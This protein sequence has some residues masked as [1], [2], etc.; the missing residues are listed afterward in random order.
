M[1]PRRDLYLFFFFN[2]Q[3]IKICVYFSWLWS[4]PSALASSA[5]S[6]IEKPC[7]ESKRSAKL[8]IR[9]G[10]SMQGWFD[11]PLLLTLFSHVT[12]VYKSLTSIRAWKK[13]A[14]VD[15]PSDKIH[16]CLDR[17]TDLNILSLFKSSVWLCYGTFDR[18]LTMPIQISMPAV[19]G[20]LFRGRVCVGIS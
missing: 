9:R 11:P 1:S 7:L 18:L 12:D 4:W 6:L 16:A 19:E 14:D 13:R 5:A 17:A 20:G 2:S 10:M 15:F 8:V 3:W